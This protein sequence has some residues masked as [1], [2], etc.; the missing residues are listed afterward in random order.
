[1]LT[2]NFEESAELERNANTNFEKSAEWERNANANFEK[3][4]EWEIKMAICKGKFP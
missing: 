1:M 2:Q 3:S 4:A